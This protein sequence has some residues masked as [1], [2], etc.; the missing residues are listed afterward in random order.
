MNCLVL[1]LKRNGVWLALSQYR[2]KP[3]LLAA[4]PSALMYY[5]G[6]R[7]SQHHMRKGHAHILVDQILKRQY[8]C[9]GHP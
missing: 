9:I 4:D 7:I 6:H 2:V 5:H 1:L 8:R 3:L